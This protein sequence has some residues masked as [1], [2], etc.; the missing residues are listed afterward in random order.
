MH[1]R[2]VKITN[3]E[4]RIDDLYHTDVWFPHSISQLFVDGFTNLLNRYILYMYLVSIILGDEHYAWHI[5][6]NHCQRSVL[7]FST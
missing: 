2:L 4:Q 1:V 6:V 3:T 7:Q 5:F